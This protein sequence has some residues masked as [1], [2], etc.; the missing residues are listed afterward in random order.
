MT[1]TL[2]AGIL[3]G[4]ASSRMGTDKAFLP[5]R[6]EPLVA[7]LARLLAPL[8]GDVVVAGGDPARF[9]PLGLRVVPDLLP[10]RCTLAGLHALLSG[11]TAD[12]VFAVA[13]DLPF[14]NADL[15][16]FLLDRRAGADAVIP[17]SDRGLEPLHAVYA[18][19]CL[20]AIEVRAREGDWKATSFHRGLRI[21]VVRIRDADWAVEG[22]SPFLNA[23]T[24]EDWRAVGP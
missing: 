8:V 20:P 19:S 13:C 5:F 12:H 9:A 14:L 6:G 1:S 15:V 3:A 7:R 21:D 18:R 2:A 22:R 11:T 10:E 4:G 16:R 17:E 23:N 24:P